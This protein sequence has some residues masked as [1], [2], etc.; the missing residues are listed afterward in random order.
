MLLLLLPFIIIIL[1]LFFSESIYCGSY[2]L[3]G[4]IGISYGK[5][6]YP[7]FIYRSVKAI[8]LFFFQANLRITLMPHIP[9][10]TKQK[11]SVGILIGITP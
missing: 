3:I 7:L 9:D 2:C 1:L 5:S 6:P 8:M 10:E 11:K 4:L